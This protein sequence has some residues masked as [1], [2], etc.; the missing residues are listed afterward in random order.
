MKELRTKEELIEKV[1]EQIE[2]DIDCGHKEAIEALVE[3]VS[4]NKLIAFLPEED[5]KK[6]KHLKTK[7]NKVNLNELIHD[8]PND[9]ELGKQLR[10][11][12]NES[13]DLEDQITAKGLSDFLEYEEAMTTDK[14]TATRIR[15]LLINLGIWKA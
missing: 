15:V 5:G 6:F 14:S 11:M 1:L 12:Y 9:G 10:K 3:L 13:N 8:F 2:F 4:I 7:E